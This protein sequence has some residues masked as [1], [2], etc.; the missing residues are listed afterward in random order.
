MLGRRW[1]VVA[2]GWLGWRRELEGEEKGKGEEG[3][4]HFTQLL[5][6]APV[7]LRREERRPEMER[8]PTRSRGAPS[9]SAPRPG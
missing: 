5:P 6:P 7:Q 1:D 3:C 9:H 8:G 2:S 4:P